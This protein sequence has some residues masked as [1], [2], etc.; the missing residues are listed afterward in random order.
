MLPF[1][2]S[3]LGGKP[4]TVNP[5]GA[6]PGMCGGGGLAAAPGGQETGGVP[7]SF[8]GV[9][10]DTS[11]LVVLTR[12]CRRFT[13]DERRLP[14]GTPP[15]PPG[16]VPDQVEGT[17]AAHPPAAAVRGRR[18]HGPAYCLNPTHHPD[19]PLAAFLFTL[20]LDFLPA[21]TTPLPPFRCSILFDILI[22]IIAPLRRPSPTFLSVFFA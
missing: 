10:T 6:L 9:Y 22:I 4:V 14:A 3:L 8:F 21:L 1:I 2:T 5:L 19:C 15:P 18:D 13:A 7:A 11:Y 16:D 12:G 20:C 17:S